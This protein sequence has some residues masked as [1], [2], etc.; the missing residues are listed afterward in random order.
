MLTNVDTCHYP[1]SP[2]QVVQ[3]LRSEG[4]RILLLAG[5]TTAGLSKD[6]KISQLV[7]LTRLGLDRI[8][9]SGNGWRLGATARLQQLATHPG[10]R[11]F[12]GGLVAEAAAAV[13]SR[14]IRNMATVG[15]NAVQVFRW[16]DPPVAYLAL[17]AEF[18]LL[19]PRGRRQVGA[20]EFYQRHPRRQLDQA[21]ILT[22]VLLPAAAAA[23]RGAFVK[24]ARTSFD[25]AMASAAAW[26]QADSGRIA[27]ARLVVGGVRTLPFRCREAEKSLA[28]KKP[29]ASLL[30]RLAEQVAEQVPANAGVRTSEAYRRRLAGVVARR[31][32][33][34]A[35]KRCSG[36]KQQ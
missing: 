2:E 9:S 4:E 16:S 1:R 25:L 24:L 34:Q 22:G 32:L 28:G 15:G 17:G 35:W 26:L 6:E 3:L 7:D 14:P 23:G 18:E 27:R 10:L 30:G 33:E 11:R 8:E 21:E 19:G 36:E 31:A 13:G 29:S 12:A 20:D 5:G